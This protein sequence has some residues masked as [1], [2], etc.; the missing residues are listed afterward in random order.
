MALNEMARFADVPVEVEVELD[1]R[2]FS[3]REILEL[4]AGSVITMSRSAGENIDLYVGGQLVGFGEIVLVE[5]HMGVRITD[6]K[7]ED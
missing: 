4:S 7:I 1:R 5:N 6:F 3:V 2:V